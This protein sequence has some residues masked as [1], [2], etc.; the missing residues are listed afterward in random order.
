MKPKL[1]YNFFQTKKGVVFAI[2]D[3]AW[4]K[5]VMMAKSDLRYVIEIGKRS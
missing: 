1:K 3:K 4:R 5:Q 2:L